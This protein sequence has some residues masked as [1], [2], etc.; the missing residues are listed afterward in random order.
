V[1]KN[2][3]IQIG[4][5]T[6]PT[7]EILFGKILLYQ[8]IYLWTNPSSYPHITPLS[9]PG[10]IPSSDPLSNPN[11]KLFYN[12]SVILLSDPLSNPVITSKGRLQCPHCLQWITISCGGFK[13][14]VCSCQTTSIYGNT[15]CTDRMTP[16]NPLLS[17][18]I[19]TQRDNNAPYD[20]HQ[21]DEDN[22]T[23]VQ[24]SE[25]NSDNTLDYKDDCEDLFHKG[26]DDSDNNLDY[27]SDSE[28]LCHE[29]EGT[30]T[31]AQCLPN[32][33]QRSNASVHK[34]QVML[35]DIVY[36]HKASLKMYDD[37]CELVKNYSSSSDFDKH[38]RLQSR[39]SFLRSIEETHCTQGLKPYHGIVQLHNDT[40]VTVPV[41]DTKQMIISMLTDPSLMNPNNFAEGYNVLT[42]DVSVDHPSNHKHGEVH[43]GD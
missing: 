33:K 11:L 35:L 24:E 14:H 18:S 43:T 29:G 7:F 31:A 42:G 20:C 13:K 16:T 37:M 6:S 5:L 21:Y 34:F 3:N 15:S 25:D 1:L 10:E 30:M 23:K 32:Y 2:L 4:Y 39:K 28:D 8:K 9:D 41:V 27:K 40:H 12:P 19:N 22:S 38:A 26:D 17:C 36:K